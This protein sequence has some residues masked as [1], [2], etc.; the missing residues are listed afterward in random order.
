VEVGMKIDI[1]VCYHNG[2]CLNGL[3]YKI[4]GIDGAEETGT[5]GADGRIKSENILPADY[6]VELDFESYNDSESEKNLEDIETLDETHHKIKIL[7]KHNN[8][9]LKLLSGLNYIIIE[10]EDENI[11][12]E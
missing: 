12:S 2:E 5:T 8:V 7:F 9:M 6:Q 4:I 11:E 3:D 1:P 10:K